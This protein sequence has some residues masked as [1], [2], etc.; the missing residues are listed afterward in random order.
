MAK[1]AEGAELTDEAQALGARV[2]VEYGRRDEAIALGAM[3]I[4]G[5]LKN[6]SAI[7]C[8]TESG[9]TPLWMSRSGSRLPIVAL[10]NQPKTLSKMALFRGVSP[11]RFDP[12]P[13][14]SMSYVDKL[15]VRIV[16]SHLKLPNDS[17][18]ILT[19]G[20]RL[21]MPGGTS[22]LKIMVVGDAENAAESTN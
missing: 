16:S 7:I 3:Y 8:I 22:T 19:R 11:L 10:S 18:V 6:L 14:Q 17:Q 5:H 12:P 21:N 9:S 13:S 20:D 15:V 1:T 4:A 2:D